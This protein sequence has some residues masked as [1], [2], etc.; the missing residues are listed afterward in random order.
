MQPA[1]PKPSHPRMARIDVDRL[2]RAATERKLLDG[3]L[4]KTGR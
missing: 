1:P 3:T 2:V 4:G